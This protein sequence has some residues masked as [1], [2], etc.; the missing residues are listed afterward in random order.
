[1]QLD[2]GL[3]ARMPAEIL[4]LDPSCIGLTSQLKRE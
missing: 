2:D 1:M 3:R 4:T